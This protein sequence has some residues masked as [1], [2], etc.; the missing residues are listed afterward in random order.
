MAPVRLPGRTKMEIIALMSA[1][2]AQF[3]R[4]EIQG[5]R[6]TTDRQAAQA[7]YLSRTAFHGDHPHL[8]AAMADHA[9][10]EP[11]AAPQTLFEPM[12]HRVLIGL[13]ADDITTAD[14]EPPFGPAPR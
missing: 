2:V 9:E 3:A 6:A 11:T 1:L 4:A 8:A 10:A 13:I 5:G 14:A 12:M 7:T